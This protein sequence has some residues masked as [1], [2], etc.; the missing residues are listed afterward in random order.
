MRQCAAMTPELSGW[1]NR[2]SPEDG[3]A[4]AAR[5]AD[6][7]RFPAAVPARFPAH[8]PIDRS[9]WPAG[10]TD[11][12]RAD[13]RLGE[14]SRTAPRRLSARPK[15]RVLVGTGDEA[16]RALCRLIDNGDSDLPR[17]VPGALM[18][19]ARDCAGDAERGRVATRP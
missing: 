3:H 4:T 14:R 12:L 16:S 8:E 9:P 10:H 15:P 11:N 1:A 18:L 7:W 13:D 19:G 17:A 2:S 5:P 6:G